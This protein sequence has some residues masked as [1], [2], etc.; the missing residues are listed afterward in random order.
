[1]AGSRVFS[2]LVTL[3]GLSV[4][5]H[6]ASAAPRQ[7][8]DAAVKKFLDA[9][10]SEREAVESQGSAVADLNG[11]GKSE[12]VLVW[13]LQGPTYWRNTLTVFAK[14]AGG[15]KPVAS[16]PLQGLAKLSSAKDGIILVDQEVYAEGDP[17]CCPS[18]KKRAKYRWAGKKISEVKR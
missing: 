5:A 18:I 4:F 6:A 3:V 14:A 1:M 11:D 17:V 7:D 9:Q 2:L 10:Q 16:F 12:L 15:Y 13:A 8:A